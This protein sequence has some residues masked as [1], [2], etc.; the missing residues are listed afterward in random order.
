MKTTYNL[1]IGLILISSLLPTNISAQSKKDMDE[2]AVRVDGLGCPFCAYG[3][4]KKMKKIK[5][6]KSLKIDMKEGLMTLK[7]PS[8]KHIDIKTIEEQV[9][10]AGYTAVYTNL[11]RWNGEFLTSKKDEVDTDNM[12][13]LVETSF[14]VYGK[15]KMCRA[16]IEK[17]VNN[18]QGIYNAKWEE[19]S[20][21]LEFKI[22]Q[23][24]ASI[25]SLHEAI[26]R[27]GHDTEKIKAK[28]EVYSNLPACCLYKRKEQ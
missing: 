11:T 10:V 18:L 28:D 15:C 20:Q 9:D 6:V 21:I 5:G 24:L 4:E 22:D 23:E 14:M 16:R 19:D 2:I 25:D 12:S 1:T 7:L 13:N 26:A 8:L 17:V 3:L 27:V